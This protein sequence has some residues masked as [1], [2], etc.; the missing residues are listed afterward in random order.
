MKYW[1]CAYSDNYKAQA[2]VLEDSVK[3]YTEYIFI[4]PSMRAPTFFS[5]SRARIGAATTLL[6]SGA[7]EVVVSGA[8]CLVT[9]AINLQ[10]F[11]YDCLFC[12]H[13]YN[14]PNE[15]Q[16]WT[17]MRGGLINS[18]FQV[19]RPGAVKFLTEMMKATKR[20]YPEGEFEIE[21]AW[22]PLALSC[23]NGKLI[24][25]PEVGVAYYNLHEREITS[26]TELIH[27]SGW[28]PKN[29]EK[30]TKY[31]MPRELNST[32]QKIFN[33]YKQLVKAYET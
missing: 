15:T 23:S 28:D 9:N 10:A 12:P 31:P 20:G 21:Q 29:P 19:W 2:K 22:L 4:R 17:F 33:E 14:L 18:D 1:V 27:F 7:E 16:L 3:K 24:E 30:F 6:Q 11:N 26:K 25:R 5:A 32:E 13:S 8:D